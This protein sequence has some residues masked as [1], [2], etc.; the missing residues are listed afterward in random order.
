MTISEANA[1]LDLI[2][3]AVALIGIPWT[4]MSYF[5]NE[6]K[7]RTQAKAALYVEANNKYLEYLALSAAH[8][9]LGLSDSPAHRAKISLTDDEDKVRQWSLF[10]YLTSVMERVYYLTRSSTDIDKNEWE[11]WERYIADY[12]LNENYR[13]YW[14]EVTVN[15]TRPTSFGTKFENYMRHQYD[16]KTPMLPTR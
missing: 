12:F 7:R 3:K 9:R 5:A 4:V 6:A 14:E 15:F 16:P 8:P 11:S 10:N 2:A 1:I 13:R